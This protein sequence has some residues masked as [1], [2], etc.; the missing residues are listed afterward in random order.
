VYLV[1][2]GGV[3]TARTQVRITEAD[4]EA[5]LLGT[6]ELEIRYPPDRHHIAGLVIRIESC[7]FPRPG[8]YWVEFH[9]D[10]DVLRREPVVVR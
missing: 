7:V 2:T 9:H 8:L 5:D 4:T 1:L 10:G 3:G 6:P